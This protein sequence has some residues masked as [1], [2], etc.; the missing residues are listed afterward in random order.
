MNT[1]QDLMNKRIL[2]EIEELREA[3]STL[4]EVVRELN[5]IV[6]ELRSEDGKD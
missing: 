4:I 2:K 1:I 6:F 5:N 3:Q